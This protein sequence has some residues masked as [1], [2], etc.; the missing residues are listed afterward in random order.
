MAFFHIHWARFSQL[1]S[2][3]PFQSLLILFH[4]LIQPIRLAFCFNKSESYFPFQPIIILLSLSVPVHPVPLPDS[5]NQLGFLW[6]PGTTPALISCH[7]NF[8]HLHHMRQLWQGI[9]V[10]RRHLLLTGTH[11]I[12]HVKRI[13]R[14]LTLIFQFSCNSQLYQ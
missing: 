6:S 7:G 13:S 2:S 3:F 5:T 9:S 8:R 4:Y 11:C 1:E 14:E 10:R 12:T